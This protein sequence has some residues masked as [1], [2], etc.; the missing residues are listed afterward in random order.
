LQAFIDTP[1]RVRDAFVSAFLYIQLIFLNLELLIIGGIAKIAG[2]AAKIPGPW[3]ASFKSVEDGANKMVGKIQGDINKIHGKNVAINITTYVSKVDV[4]TPQ[5]HHDSYEHGGVTH[6]AATG[7]ARGGYTLVGE[8]GPEL[9]RLPM[10]STVY[11]NAQSQSM[12]S[13]GGGGPMKFVHEFIFG[14]GDSGLGTLLLKMQ[15]DGQLKVL[16]KAIVNV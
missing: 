8:H 2:I 15:R 7:G 16:T 13:N 4:G 6:T 11:S 12:M 9:A 1:K 14:G 5:T 10:G 3:Q